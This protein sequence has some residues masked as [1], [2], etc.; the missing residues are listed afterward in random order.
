MRSWK[1]TWARPAS[2]VAAGLIGLLAA[3]RPA[4]AIELRWVG[5]D[6]HDVVGA[7][8]GPAGNDYQDI[9]WTLRGLPPRR[10]IAHAVLR[11]H[12][13]GEWATDKPRGTDLIVVV[14]RPNSPTADL[15]VEPFGPEAGR[16]FEIHVRLD[17]GEDLVAYAQGGKANPNLRAKGAA[18]PTLQWAGP[19]G[20][21]RVGLTPSVGP[22]GVEDVRL[23]VAGLSARSPVRSATLTAKGSAGVAWA[24]GLNPDGHRNAEFLPDPS[25]PTRAELLIGVDRDLRGAAL[26]LAIH[27][28]DGRVETATA[29]AGSGPPPRAVPAPPLPDLDTK[30]LRARWLG[31]DATGAE[32]GDV[33]VA[34]EGLEPGRAILSAAVG[35]GVV[36]AWATRGSDGKPAFGLPDA[37]GRLTNLGFKDGSRTVHLAFPPWRDETGAGMTLRARDDRGREYIASFPG[38]P[39][40]IL[41]RTPALPAGSASAKP[42]DD[43]QALVG[44]HGTVRLRAGTHRLTKPLVLSRTVRI[45]GEPGAVLQ[46]D[47]PQDAPAWTAAIKV[48][49]G[50]TTL[51]GFA[52]RFAGPVRWDADVQYGPAVIGTTDNRDPAQSPADPKVGVTL[53][54][55]DLEAPPAAAKDGPW[56]PAAHL[57]RVKTATC[58]RVEGNRLRGGSVLFEGG[59]WVIRGNIYRGTPPRT[60]C[61]DVF[62][63]SWTHDLALTGNRVAV[64]AP[65]GKTWRF[66]VLT[67]RGAND[68][69]ADNE[70]RGI[71]AREDDPI[72]HPNAPELILT[73]AYRLHFEGKPAAVSK[74]GRILTIPEP[75]GSPDVGIGDAISILAGP[76]A[77]TWRSIALPLGPRTFLLDAPVDPKVEAISVSTG[78]ARETFR[79]NVVDV[80][81]SGQAAA[82]VLAGNLFG[83]QVAG[84]RV[85]GGGESIRLVAS[86]SEDPRF[87]GWSHAPVLGAKVQGNRF[88][89]GLAGGI[90]VE[91]TQHTKTS[92]G[93]VYL[94]AE[95]V[96]NVVARTGAGHPKGAG[97][98]C[99]RVG[100]ELARD[101]G[102]VV[103]AERGTKVEGLTR[104][105]AV[106]VDAQLNG[107]ITRETPPAGKPR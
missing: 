49:R 57:I 84:N 98:P 82:L 40:D 19:A 37:C 79:N 23:R 1:R 66:L 60:F 92:Q 80:R 51:E 104:A 12:G 91:R 42:G 65:A 39:A 59:P 74:D 95:L 86:A 30:T 58:G 90:G 93:R 4:A 8:P 73:E 75:Q 89:D 10:A 29:R 16:E 17:T 63:G 2:V 44:K 13:G 106:R 11:G 56:E 54:R 7:H 9:H 102:E 81:G 107:K 72:P 97:R 100:S 105:E 41:R 61:Y 3:A 45:E 85:E 35:D 47:Q 50:G 53:A 6:G 88:V 68:L 69:V 94:S 24:A 28:E 62:A 33:V 87:W 64:D 77:G 38:G 43:L 70:V 27:H 99:L 22:D 55:L 48:H 36:G 71:G 25:D 83:V 34:V 15:Y 78:F 96:D 18:G 101:P 103:V 32:P 67:Q 46:F 21:D 20:V 5:Q 26:E 31:H 14:R 52:V 76:G